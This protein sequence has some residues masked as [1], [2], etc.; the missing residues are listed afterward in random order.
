MIKS[1]ADGSVL[2]AHSYGQKLTL[3][4]ELDADAAE[5]L[6]F[7]NDVFA[8]K[9]GRYQNLEIALPVGKAIIRAVDNLGRTAC[10][11]CKAGEIDDIIN[12]G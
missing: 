12:Y 9:S 6:W 2:I 11:G 5:T 10:G 1:P 8:G 7:V 3:S 4:A